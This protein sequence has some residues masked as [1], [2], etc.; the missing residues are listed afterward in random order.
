M[1][2]DYTQHQQNNASVEQMHTDLLGTVSHELRS[3]LA[4]IKGYAAMLLRHDKHLHRDERRE[5]L[6]A[7]YQATN[8]LSLIVDRLLEMAQLESDEIHIER[9]PVDMRRLALESIEAIRQ[10]RRYQQATA[11]RSDVFTFVVQARDAQGQR[12]D[13]VPFVWADQRYLRQALDNILENALKFSPRG[14]MITITLQPIT[15]QPAEGNGTFDTVTKQ[16]Q[17]VPML[18]IAIHDEGMGIPDEHLARIFERFQRVDTRL[19]REV[20][21]LGLGLAIC[22]RIIALHNGN[23]WAESQP[24]AGSTFFIQLPLIEY[25]EV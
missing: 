25:N 21:G 13:D 18:Q 3:P 17:A 19:T 23:L 22:K 7:I 4:S 20:N 5:Y 2:A 16:Q 24:E 15:Q 8:D 11:A 14:G 10:T 1:P 6:E 9:G 12:A